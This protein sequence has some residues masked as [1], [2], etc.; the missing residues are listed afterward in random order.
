MN[1]RPVFCSLE[2]HIALHLARRSK[3]KVLSLW[4]SPSSVLAFWLKSRK[5]KIC[6]IFADER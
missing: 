2:E 4:L 5:Q 6:P 3:K 1:P